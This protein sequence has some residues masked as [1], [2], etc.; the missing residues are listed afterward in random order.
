MNMHGKE[1]KILAV[2][3]LAVMIN[4]G[5]AGA[6]AKKVKETPAPL[7]VVV[8]SDHMRYH[9]DT[10]DIVAEGNVIITQ[11]E[12]VIRAAVVEGNS[13]SGDV[14]ID[15]KATYEAVDAQQNIALTGG[16]VVYNWV[17]RKGSVDEPKGHVN[18]E[19]IRGDSIELLPDR[20]I[21]HDGRVTRCEREDHPHYCMTADRIEIIPNVKMT[22]YN[23]KVLFFGRVLYSQERYTTSLKPEDRNQES[24]LLPAI[25]YRSENGLYVRQRLSQ[26]LAER[27]DAYADINYYSKH[28]FTPAAGVVY[29]GNGY[30]LRIVDGVFRDSDGD[31]LIKEPEL[32]FSFDSRKI[33]HSPYSYAIWGSYGKWDDDEKS[34]WH[35]EEKIYVS[36]EPIYLDADKSLYLT[37]GAGTGYMHESYLSDGWATTNYD[38]VIYKNWQRWQA[39]TGYHYNRE[40]R[41]L[42]EYDRSDLSNYWETGMTYHA[43]AKDSFGVI[44]RYDMDDNRIY[45]LDF[46]WYRNL[47][48]CFQMEFTYRQKQRKVEYKI[49]LLK[50]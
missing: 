21:V 33:G 18:K 6:A 49:H 8:T 28:G 9:D 32:Q 31:K 7:P 43:N 1:T 37:L 29:G 38:G 48:D 50:W 40:N 35:N 45:D 27:V 46:K 11:G 5:A 44:A 26:P 4:A 42:F 2:G 39:N 20:Y 15:G 13:K 30:S 14:R 10:G 16:P 19:N 41:N 36:R 12:K 3:L 25:G 47:N 34:S 17:Q 23:A 22:A 24:S